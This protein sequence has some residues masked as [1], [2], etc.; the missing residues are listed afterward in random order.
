[1]VRVCGRENSLSIPTIVENERP[2]FDPKEKA[3]SFNDY[4]VLQTEIAGANT[5]SPVIPPYQTQQFLSSFIATEE[6]VL[7]LM[8]GVD[9]SKAAITCWNSPD[10]DVRNSVSLPTFKAK[11]RSTLFP[12]TYNRYAAQRDV[13]TSAANILGVLEAG[14]EHYANDTEEHNLLGVDDRNASILAIQLHPLESSVKKYLVA[15]LRTPFI[16]DSNELDYVTHIKLLGVVIDNLLSFN[17]HIKEV[18]R[19]V[20][21]KVSILRR[22]RKFIPSDVMIKLYKAFI[23]PHFEYASPLFIGLSKGLSAKLESTN[24]F[25]L[26][27]LLNYSKS[28]AYEDLEH[29][30]IE[31]ALIL[32]YKSIHNQ[33]PNYIQEMF[34][35]RSN[36][37]S[38]RGHL[39]VVLPRPT[40]SYMQHSFTYQASKQWNNLTD[41][42]RMSESLS[43]FRKNLQDIQLSSSYDCSCLFCKQIV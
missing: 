11:T 28:T 43:I 13:L 15:T 25:A 26:R 19:K 31:Q 8:K 42:I 32:V 14:T 9:T 40:S 27:T 36:G 23:L 37:Y 12:H 30:R 35:L 22:I 20:N 34:S 4:F 17:V 16:I 33:T 7:E 41:K 24:A 5:I 39:K 38:L 3:C 18:C 1:M 6:Q 10:L 2:I 21:T 29:R